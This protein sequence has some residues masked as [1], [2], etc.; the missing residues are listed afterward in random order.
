MSQ[1][2]QTGLVQLNGL[3]ERAKTQ[4]ALA[5]PKHLTPERMIRMAMTLY[6][7]SDQLK[8][9]DLT[10]ILACVIQSS[11]LGLELSSPLGHAFMVPYGTT[12]TFQIGYKGYMELAFRSGKVSAMPMRTVYAND[13]FKVRYGTDQKIIH[14]PAIKSRGEVIGYYAAIYLKD[15]GRDFEW[16]SVEDIAEHQKHYVKNK[17]TDSPWNTARDAMAMKT[18]VR[19]LAKRMPVS[20]EWNRAASID[21]QQEFGMPLEVELNGLSREARIGAAL[22][23][24]GSVIDASSEE[25]GEPKTDVHDEI[26][27][28]AEPN[29]A[30]ESKTTEEKPPPPAQVSSKTLARLQDLLSKL[31]MVE[32]SFRDKIGIKKWAELLEQDAIRHVANL[33]NQLA[34]K[35]SQREPSEE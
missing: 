3:L 20:T 19:M 33:E 28:E 15:G 34:A 29:T 8:K 25:K 11:E 14:E 7:K 22:N 27:D 17:R 32:R 24:N 4:I 16:M 30:A 21:E 10:T 1:Q 31:D 35:R 12:A 26:K 13:V 2:Q 18:C 6:G 9:C 5:L 23:G